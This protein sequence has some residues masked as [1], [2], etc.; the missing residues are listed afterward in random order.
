MTSAMPTLVVTRLIGTAP[1]IVYVMIR[2][3]ICAMAI[4]A[5]SSV[6]IVGH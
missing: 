3:I 4:G 2:R 1:V 6:H 5:R